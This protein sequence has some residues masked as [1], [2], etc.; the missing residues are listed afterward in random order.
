MDSW[1]PR[2]AFPAK[3]QAVY[4]WAGTIRAAQVLETI[5]LSLV[6]Q[7]VYGMS[8]VFLTLLQR[9]TRIASKLTALSIQTNVDLLKV[10]CF[11]DGIGHY[12]EIIELLKL[13]GCPPSNS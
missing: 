9:D 13:L 10:D 1:S 7:R 2:A 5:S 8:E 4:G 3:C 6:P 11:G 12:F